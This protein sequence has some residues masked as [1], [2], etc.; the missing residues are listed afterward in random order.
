MAKVKKEVVKETSKTRV[1][2]V[3][4]GSVLL[5]LAMSGKGKEGGYARGRIVNLVGDGSSGKTLLALEACAQVYY[6]LNRKETDLFPVAKKITIVYNNVEGVMDFPIEAMYGEELVEAIEWVRF[7]TAETVGRDY[8]KR[9]KDLKKGEFLLYI[10]DS[11]DAMSSTASKKRAEESIKKEKDQD[12]SYGMEK[13]KYFSSTLFPR[14]CEYMEGKDATMIC[15]SQ[16]RENI[17]AGLF[18]AKHYRAGGKALDFFTHQVAWLAQVGKLSKEFRSTKKIYGVR[19][20][21]VL[22]RNKVAKPF[23]DAEFDILFDY[24]V[25]DM[26]SMLTYLY[27]GAKKIIW[28]EEEID[29]I[30]LIKLMEDNPKEYDKLVT[31]VETEWN[32]IEEKIKPKR[33]RR[34]E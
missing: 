27:G 7:D 8:L 2:F 18:G 23:R 9:V 3:S 10:I 4:T 11:I 33:K 13:Q 15:I 31:L 17:N 30:D 29:R 1:E 19:T 6:N 34:F 26:G 21:A 14:A 28:N 12:G 32:E 24:G 20:K 25:D 22:K 16:V 5:N